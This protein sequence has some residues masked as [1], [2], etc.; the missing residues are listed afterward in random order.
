MTTIMQQREVFSSSWTGDQAMDM[1][2]TSE[3]H[4]GHFVGLKL[5]IVGYSQQVL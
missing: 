5:V 2:F 1:E 3:L 4:T